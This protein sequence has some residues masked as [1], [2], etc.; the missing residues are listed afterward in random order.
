MLLRELLYYNAGAK[1]QFI[2]NW[3]SCGNELRS[4]RK[5][6]NLAPLELM[7]EIRERSASPCAKHE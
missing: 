6:A 5:H 3:N 4:D 7:V 2:W 1:L